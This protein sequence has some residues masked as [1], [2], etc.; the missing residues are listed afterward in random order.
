MTSERYWS[1]TLRLVVGVDLPA[2]LPVLD[3][4]LRAVRVGGVERG[5]HVLQA[6]AVMEEG[7]RIELGAHRR[8]RAAPDRDLADA[9]YLRQLLL[10]DGGG[11]VVELPLTQRVG[12]ERQDQHR[13]VGRVDLLVGGVAPERGRQVG[14]RGVDRRLHVPRGAVDVAVEAELQG[15]L[16]LADRARRGHLGDVG[17]LAEMALERGRDAGRHRLGA[18]AGKLRRDLDGREIDLRQRRHRQ[19]QERDRRRP[20]PG[21]G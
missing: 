9:V 17:D 7:T 18:G 15:D 6:D 20:A 13:R 2:L 21:R 8:Q 3:G 5:S 19:Q 10:Q 12:G 14:A 11:A 1:A 16:R 4:A